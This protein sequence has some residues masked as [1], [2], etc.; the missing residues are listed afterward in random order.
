MTK[1]AELGSETTAK[2]VVGIL[3]LQVILANSDDVW[4]AQALEIDYAA[5]GTTP[6]EA[7]KN[8][9]DGLFATIQEHLTVFNTLDNF[10]K[11][12]PAK[13]WLSLV[14]DNVT[15]LFFSQISIHE[16]PFKTIHYYLPQAA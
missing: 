13:L 7:K 9:E 8:F 2:A 10:I 4:I 1:L 12:A 5:E 16:F 15:A 14:K 3:D 11:P 6:E